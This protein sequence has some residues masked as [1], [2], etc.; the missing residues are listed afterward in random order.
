MSALGLWAR[1]R[2]GDKGREGKRMMLKQ[3]GQD[4]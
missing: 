3:D 2:R 4:G 1:A